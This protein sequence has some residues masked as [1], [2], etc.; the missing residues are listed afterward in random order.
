MAT[1]GHTHTHKLLLGFWTKAR[2]LYHNLTLFNTLSSC[3][4][5]LCYALREKERVPTSIN[6]YIS[7]LPVKHRKRDLSAI[8]GRL[9]VWRTLNGVDGDYKRLHHLRREERVGG[10][11]MPP[12]Y[13]GRCFRATAKEKVNHER[14]I[15]DDGGQKP[16]KV[17][18]TCGRSHHRKHQGVPGML[19][20]DASLFPPGFFSPC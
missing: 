7:P 14:M 9:L 19:S 3:H 2:R 18:P 8:S 15:K 11:V 6:S 1:A 13:D 5:F 16:T 4:V 12:V 17:R 10:Y 20:F